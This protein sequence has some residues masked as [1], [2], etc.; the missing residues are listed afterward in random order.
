[1]Q[2]GRTDRSEQDF[3]HF[4]QNEEK[5]KLMEHTTLRNTKT[6]YK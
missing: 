2:L 3:E 6:F 1:M 5:H 4:Y